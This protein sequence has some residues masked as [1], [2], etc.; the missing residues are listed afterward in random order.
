M[1]DRPSITRRSVVLGAFAQL[2]KATITF[3]IFARLSALMEQ[4]GSH[5]AHFYEI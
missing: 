4:L 2:R 1:N 3:A 5:W